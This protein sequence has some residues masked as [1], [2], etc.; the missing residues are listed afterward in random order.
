MLMKLQFGA[1]VYASL[2]VRTG[3]KKLLAKIFLAQLF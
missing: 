2:L 1:L 3:A